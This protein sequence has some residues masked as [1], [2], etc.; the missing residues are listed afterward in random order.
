MGHAGKEEALGPVRRAFGLELGPD[1]ARQQF[2]PVHFV[3]LVLDDEDVQ[4]AAAEQAAEP[5]EGKERVRKLQHDRRGHRDAEGEDHPAAP[6]Q[7]A[8]LAP[9]RDLRQHDADRIERDQQQERQLAHGAFLVDAVGSD[10][11]ESADEAVQDQRDGEEGQQPPPHPQRA[12]PR[13]SV[14]LQVGD[15]VARPRE[16]GQ[17]HHQEEEHRVRI[18]GEEPFQSREHAPQ[19]VREEEHRQAG[20]EA[21]HLQRARSRTGVPPVGQLPPVD[22]QVDQQRDAGDDRIKIGIDEFKHGE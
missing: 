15:D 3:A 20:E 19:H 17:R 21:P 12:P 7:G 9:Q 18:K 6:A 13:P 11:E 22:D 10:R 16:D 4:E 2:L 5:I 8:L 14:H 1:V